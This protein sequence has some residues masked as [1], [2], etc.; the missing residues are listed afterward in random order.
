MT[1]VQGY[2]YVARV[3]NAHAWVEAFDRD[4]G[5]WLLVEPPPPSGAPN[6]KHEWSTIESWWYMMKKAFQQLLSNMRAVILRRRLLDFLL[7]FGN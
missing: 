3:G 5:Q 2:Y 7:L 4:K 1:R 6:Y